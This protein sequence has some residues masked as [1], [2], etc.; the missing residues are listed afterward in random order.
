MINCRSVS[1][2]PSTSSSHSS[3]VIH[4]PPQT[5]SSDHGPLSGLVPSSTSQQISR[6]LVVVNSS[7]PLP[8][9]DTI[10][11]SSSMS[12]RSAHTGQPKDVTSSHQSSP[13]HTLI[14]IPP[15]VKQIS[16]SRPVSSTPTTNPS[17]AIV[18]KL[19][20][21][22]K[23]SGS[24][25]VNKRSINTTDDGLFVRYEREPQSV[26]N[27]QYRF[28]FVIDEHS[29]ALQKRLRYVSINDL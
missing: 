27:D 3:Y 10:L 19:S 23:L 28:S 7:E 13:K 17:T 22:S 2:P 15:S 9:F 24:T 1:I 20:T 18:P 25:H 21:P 6:Q 14:L 8:S 4:H 5:N 12:N 29:P 11:N 26:N 16:S